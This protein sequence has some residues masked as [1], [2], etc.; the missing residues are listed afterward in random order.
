MSYIRAL[1]NPESLYIW[2]EGNGKVA[3][4][5]GQK[6]L[7]WMPRHVFH[8]ILKRWY[9]YQDVA[10]YRGASMKMIFTAP[11]KIRLEYPKTG[12]YV[13]CYEATWV[14]VCALNEYRWK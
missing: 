6:S 9:E 1:S 3:I 11:F 14:Y 13:E 8:G 4:S 2:G 5:V 12:V 10:K 7:V